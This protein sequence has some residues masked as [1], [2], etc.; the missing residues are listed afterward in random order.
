MKLSTKPV[1][2]W[3]GRLWF[4]MEGGLGC[5]CFSRHRGTIVLPHPGSALGSLAIA[6]HGGKPERAPSAG[7]TRARYG[8]IPGGKKGKKYKIKSRETAED[9][10]CWSVLQSQLV[11]PRHGAYDKLAKDKNPP[12]TGMRC[13]Y[14]H[15]LFWAFSLLISGVLMGCLGFLAERR[16]LWNSTITWTAVLSKL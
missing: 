12:S 15:G 7:E 5:L 4:F 16:N 3:F 14:F 9:V 2:P 10:R 8:G 1:L 13:Q 6:Q 11:P